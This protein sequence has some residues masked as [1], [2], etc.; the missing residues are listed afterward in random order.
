MQKKKGVRMTGHEERTGMKEKRKAVFGGPMKRKPDERKQAGDLIKEPVK[1]NNGAPNYDPN[2]QGHI[3][4]GEGFPA[5]M[6]QA[7]RDTHVGKRR[8]KGGKR[9]KEEGK[10]KAFLAT[11][12]ASRDTP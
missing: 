12:S 5:I 6:A 7:S 10:G 8:E 4:K 1:E 9:E 3:K 2:V 11:T